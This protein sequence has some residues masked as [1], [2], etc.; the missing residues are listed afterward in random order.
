MV[1]ITDVTV[2]ISIEQPIA[3]TQ[4]DILDQYLQ[5]VP[6]SVP[7]E[8]HIGGGVARGYLNRPELTAEKFI[9]NPFSDTP[10]SR[11]PAT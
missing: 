7:G 8:L 5:P 10:N 6:L 1:Q 2:P 3:N 9:N 4:I 11:L